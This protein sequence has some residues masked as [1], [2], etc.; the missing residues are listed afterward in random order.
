MSEEVHK[1]NQDFMP[2]V[3]LVQYFGNIEGILAA[4]QPTINSPA[5]VC[6]LTM[7]VN[8]ITACVIEEVQYFKYNDKEVDAALL[9]YRAGLKKDINHR[10]VVTLFGDLHKLL[11]NV[12]KRVYYMNSGAVIT[13]YLS[14]C[15]TEPVLTDDLK[16][17]VLAASSSDWWMKN[18][19]LKTVIEAIRQHIPGFSPWKGATDDFIAMLEN[20]RN[21]RSALLPKK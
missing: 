14:P 7:N 16:Y 9:K 6:T 5:K 17:Y 12:T 2:Q 11:E 18:E 19:A 1:E 3:T 8:N 20:E 15:I 10:E 13:T 21:R 4:F